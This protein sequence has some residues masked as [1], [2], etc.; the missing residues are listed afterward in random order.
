MTDNVIPIQAVVYGEPH[1]GTTTI[2][3]PVPLW[4]QNM[5]AQ[6]MSFGYPKS[7]LLYGKPGTRKTSLAASLV[8]RPDRPTVVVLDVDN[9][10]ESIINDAEMMQAYKEGRL[11]IRSID[12]E[13]PS[14]FADIDFILND[15]AD[16]DYGFDFFIVDTLNIAQEV[17]RDYKLK[18]TFNTKNQ[19]DTQAGWGEIGIWTNKVAR[20]LHNAPHVCA[21]FVM[22]E[23]V[24]TA[25]TGS[26]SILP[27]LQG[28]SKDSIAAIPSIVAHLSFQKIGDKE[29][30]DIV[31]SLGGSDIHVTKNR[32][33]AFLENRMTDFSLLDLY[34]K[35]DEHLAPTATTNPT[36]AAV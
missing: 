15:V 23:T 9:G 21:I 20:K 17:A 36:A 8:K 31:A 18:T 33:S 5:P 34:A 22:H 25:E 28:G 35:L 4:L 7:I 11:I 29:T 13:S 27:K 14:A 1:E 26:V 10:A 3:K 2:A 32:Y 19:L 24:A 16:N 6:T 12:P 30:T